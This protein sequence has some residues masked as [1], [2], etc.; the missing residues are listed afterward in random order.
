LREMNGIGWHLARTCPITTS[1]RNTR[2]WLPP[3]LPWIQR[4][5]CLSMKSS[6]IPGLHRTRLVLRKLLGRYRNVSVWSKRLLS[7]RG[8]LSSLG[9][10]DT[11][12]DLEQTLVVKSLNP[13]L[14]TAWGY[15]SQVETP[16][17]G[18][19]ASIAGL[20]TNSPTSTAHPALMNYSPLWL[21][22]STAL[23]MP[24]KRWKLTRPTT[25]WRS[26]FCRTST[27]F[28]SASELL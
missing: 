2:A 21:T 5:G 10:N 16:T 14:P 17:H 20:P 24:R 13:G 6:S 9:S 12:T 23:R 11:Q 3:C 18:H 19:F 8:K 28:S 7:R 26:L 27:K 25:N 4:R 15:P 1:Q 22:T